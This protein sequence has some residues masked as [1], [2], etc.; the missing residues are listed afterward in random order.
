MAARLNIEVAFA[1]A[2]R[3]RRSIRLRISGRVF[4]DCGLALCGALWLGVCCVDRATAQQSGDAASADDELA[5]PRAAWRDLLDR[6]PA[7]YAIRRNDEDR[8]PL[9]PLPHPVLR[10]ANYTRRTS[11]LIEVREAATYIWTFRGR[12]EAVAC[13]SPPRR[14]R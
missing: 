1:D 14:N 11:D 4:L 6:Q 7:E 10:W 13:A 12:P 9:V 5:K 2:V 3:S 8:S